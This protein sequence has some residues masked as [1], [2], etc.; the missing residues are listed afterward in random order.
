MSNIQ[1]DDGY[2]GEIHVRDAGAGMR[3]LSE[4]WRMF[5]LN[6]GLWIGFI[7]VMFTL[8]IVVQVLGP[9]GG[10]ASS[11]LTPILSAGIMIGCDRVHRG[12]GALEFDDLFKA[13]R[14]PHLVPLLIM[15]VI[16]L[17][18][19]IAVVVISIVP[20]MGAFFLVIENNSFGG[21]EMIPILLG[22]AF[23]SALMLP[24]M[25]AT[26][27]A[28]PLIVLNQVAPFDALKMSLVGCFKNWLPFL[29]YGLVTL[30]LAIA[31]TL[32]LLIGWIVLA[33]VIIAS[34]YASY[35]DIYYANGGDHV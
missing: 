1:G 14:E 5:S 28:G 27:M 19:A 12:G 35:R 6:P 13:F 4:A 9:F 29:I 21:M 32:P 23:F 30:P 11:L 26:W 3:W 8:S 18:A 20:I 10:I 31:A 25:A 7:L 17:G 33:P 15:G 16:Y 22:A 2:T 24:L 34:V